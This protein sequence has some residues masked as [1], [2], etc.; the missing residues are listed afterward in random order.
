[1]D[2]LDLL[3][4]SYDVRYVPVHSQ[5]L[6]VPSKKLRVQNG[7]LSLGYCEGASDIVEG[8]EVFDQC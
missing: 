8:C 4:A 7:L 5:V 6:I 2:F 3:L 1:M